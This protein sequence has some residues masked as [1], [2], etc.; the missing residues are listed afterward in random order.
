MAFKDLAPVHPAGQAASLVHM[1]QHRV[2]LALMESIVQA[3]AIQSALI[4][5]QGTFPILIEVT[6]AHFVQQANILLM[7]YHN[8]HHPHA[9]VVRP[10]IQAPSLVYL[11]QSH[12]LFAQ[13]ESIVPLKQPHALIVKQG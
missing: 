8:V 6:V 13:M 2:L 5:Q 11:A 12:A 1:A 7:E 10:A 9:V 4:A 3:Q